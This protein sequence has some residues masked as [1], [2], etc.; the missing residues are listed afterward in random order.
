MIEEV[1]KLFKATILRESTFEIK[2]YE[3]E[4]TV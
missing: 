4:E 2:Q 1:L 3:V